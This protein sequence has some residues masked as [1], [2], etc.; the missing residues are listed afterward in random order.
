MTI[1]E[2]TIYTRNSL[3]SGD[4]LY[5]RYLGIYRCKYQIS[6]F[7]FKSSFLSLP[8]RQPPRPLLFIAYFFF[9]FLTFLHLSSRWSRLLLGREFDFKDTHVLRVWDYLFCSST[10]KEAAFKNDHDSNLESSSECAENIIRD[11]DRDGIVAD[12]KSKARSGPTYCPILVTLRDFML[13]ML[14][15]VSTT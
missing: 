6:C 3:V 8:S 7:M 2:R 1:S 15:H 13:A 14:I 5:F 12:R 11:D 9:L 4:D 10:V